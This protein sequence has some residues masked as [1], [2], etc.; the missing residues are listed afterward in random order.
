MLKMISMRNDMLI[1]FLQISSSLFD[2]EDPTILDTSYSLGEQA[3]MNTVLNGVLAGHA[4]GGGHCP[5]R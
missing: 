2:N 4:E 3:S 5:R 1:V